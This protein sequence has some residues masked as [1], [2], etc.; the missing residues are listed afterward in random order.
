MIK[1]LLAAL[2]LA[3]IATESIDLEAGCGG[4]RG[5]R[6]GFFASRSVQ[7]VRVFQRSRS[8]ECGSPAYMA[9]HSQGCSDG[10]ARAR[11][12]QQPPVKMPN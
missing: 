2:A 3:F 10:P 6:R 1:F 4:R 9:I 12:P 8:S 7:R 11:E 5:G